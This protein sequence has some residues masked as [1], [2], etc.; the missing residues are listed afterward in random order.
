MIS[1]RQ[2]TTR[3]ALAGVRACTAALVG[4]ATLVD[5]AGAQRAILDRAVHSTTLPNGLQVIAVENHDAPDV[6]IQVVAR[7]GSLVQATPADEGNA[8]LFEHMLFK[9]YRSGAD[10]MTGWAE[11]V[12]ALHGLGYNG[13]TV[14]EAVAYYVDVPPSSLDGA[15]QLM[16]DLVRGPVF[17]RDD[18]N[19]EA[20]VVINEFQRTYSNPLFHLQNEVQ[21]RLWG[22]GWTQKNTLGSSSAILAA[23]PASLTKTFG[24]YY[25][26]NNAA[27]MIVGDVDAARVFEAARKYFSRWARK[28]DPFAAHA[29]AAPPPLEQDQA[30]LV[31]DDVS[32]VTLLVAWQGPSVGTDS[33]DVNAAAVLADVLNEPA[34]E[35]QRHLI[36]PGLFTEVHMEYQEQSR[37]GPILLMATAPASRLAAALPAL[38]HE[39]AQLDAGTAVSAEELSDLKAR[40]VVERA[41]ELEEPQTAAFQ[42][43]QE[44]SLT[45]SLDYYLERVDAENAQLPAALGQVAHRYIAQQPRV[46]GALCAPRD[47]DVVRRVLAPWLARTGARP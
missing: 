5:A 30:V 45:R 8:H 31:N 20:L 12:S 40:R 38:D 13:F 22:A 29:T 24:E 7:S 10:N 36:T 16:A 23:N 42:L 47:N 35:F 27:L 2:F 3:V 43:A 25:V 37:I 14:E 4:A 46:T 1:S 26:P 6:V 39:L 34:S 44:W 15:V 33:S 41:L 28:P 11:A 17:S 21:K 32:D 19:R 9:S 18:V